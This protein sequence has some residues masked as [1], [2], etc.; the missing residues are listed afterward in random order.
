MKYKTLADKLVERYSSVG[1][2]LSGTSERQ[3]IDLVPQAATE[4]SIIFE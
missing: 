2:K 4:F 1:L 3:E